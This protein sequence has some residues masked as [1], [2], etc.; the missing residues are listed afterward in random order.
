MSQTMKTLT[1]ITTTYNRAYCL[2][3]VYDSLCRQRSNDF[4]WMIIDDGSTDNTKDLVS[5]WKKDGIIDI[6]Y[7]S[8]QNGGMHTARNLAY[9]NVETEINV[10]ID[11]DDWMTD[12][13]VERII[14]FWSQNKSD[15]YYGIVAYNISKEGKLI[16]TQFPKGIK[17]CTLSE[18]VNKYHNKGDKKIVL[19]SDL[20]K[21]YPFPVFPGE[22]FYPASYKYKM[23]D[24]HYKLLLMPENVCVVDYNPDSMTYTKYIQYRSCCCGF[25][26]YRN[27]IMRISKSPKEIF[28]EAVHYVS[29]SKFAGNAHYVIRCSK[30]LYVTMIWPI[31]IVYH[32]YLLKTNKK[33]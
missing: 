22:K 20:S 33:F 27:E 29:E 14:S 21:K 6:T 7:I 23:L 15:R 3:Q 5:S 2:P 24:L 18:L 10:I 28:R 4:V 30:P 8:K 13:A 16:G 12:D 19:R 32:W 17:S 26:H 31:G 9:E 25:A 11:S 1:V